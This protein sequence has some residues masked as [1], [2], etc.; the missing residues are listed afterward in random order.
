M[1]CYVLEYWDQGSP[2][3]AE[4]AGSARTDPDQCQ[5]STDRLKKMVLPFKKIIK[6][7]NRSE[8][9]PNQPEP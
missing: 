7:K 6:K 1:A 5:Y 4:P 2:N 3:H 8:P 9:V